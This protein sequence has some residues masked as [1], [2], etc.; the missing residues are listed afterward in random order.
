L[1]TRCRGPK[2]RADRRPDFGTASPDDWF[3]EAVRATAARVVPIEQRISYEA[4]RVVVETGHKDPGDCFLMATA[5]IRRVALVTRDSTIGAI[6]TGKPGY[7]DV[8]TC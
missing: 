3:R 1:G 7:L 8:V 6:A 5:R 2:A 4:A